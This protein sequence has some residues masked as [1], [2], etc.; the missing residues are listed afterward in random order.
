MVRVENPDKTIIIHLEY[1][2]DLSKYV[3]WIEGDEYKGV[4]LEA[5]SLGECIK[6][7][8]I[9]LKVLELYRKNIKSE[10]I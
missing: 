9:S 7:L 2:E 6:E 4:V 1:F 3:A 5:D 10:K 8:G